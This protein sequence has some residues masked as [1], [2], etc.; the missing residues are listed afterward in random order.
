MLN[1]FKK[2]K[3]TYV[4]NKEITFDVAYKINLESYLDLVKFLNDDIPITEEYL[5]ELA[6][7]YN[8]AVIQIARHYEELYPDNRLP[9]RICDLNFSEYDSFDLKKY[10]KDTNNYFLYEVAA[11]GIFYLDSNY[12]RSA[13]LHV[14]D[15]IIVEAENFNL[16]GSLSPILASNINSLLT[17]LDIRVAKEVLNKM[18]ILPIQSEIKKITKQMELQE[19][20]NQNFLLSVIYFMLASKKS[21]KD[22]FR[23]MIFANDLNINFNFGPYIDLNQEQRL[24]LE[25]K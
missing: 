18:N 1:I 23:A 17:G 2:K 22:I 9:E 25:K 4:K 19:R 21:N 20:C 3:S 14:E 7:S 6:N 11:N 15:S 13:H 10:R 5:R 12:F 24:L 16:I 8:K